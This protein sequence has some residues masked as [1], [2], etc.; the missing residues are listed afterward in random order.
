MD[1][2]ELI[3]VEED[4]DQ[5]FQLFVQLNQ[6]VPGH[7]DR[8]PTEIVAAVKAELT[9]KV[10]DLDRAYEVVADLLAETRFG[11]EQLKEN[12]SRVRQ[13]EKEKLATLNPFFS[14]PTGEA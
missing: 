12:Q 9:K 10:K 5:L 1:L 2:K 14:R 3:T 4:R 8:T 11:M 7:K 6:I 13:R